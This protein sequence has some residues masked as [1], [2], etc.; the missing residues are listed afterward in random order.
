MSTEESKPVSSDQ[1]PPP[2]APPKRAPIP[3]PASKSHRVRNILIALA[4]L[5][6]SLRYHSTHCPL[7][8]HRLD[9]RC[10]CQ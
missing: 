8:A 9:R 2:T 5:G 1:P 4:V 6:T 7:V 10:L 3:P